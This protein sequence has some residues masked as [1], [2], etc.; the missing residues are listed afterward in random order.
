MA[1]T[2][3]RAWT[4]EALYEHFT[5]RIRGAVLQL[6]T[7][8]AGNRRQYL[9]KFKAIEQRFRSLE[10]AIQ[11]AAA[12]IQLQFKSVNELRSMV[13]DAQKTYATLVETRAQNEALV[14]RLDKVEQEQLPKGEYV[15]RMGALEKRQD[16]LERARQ[17][18]V[19][20]GT[21]FG[22]GW[23]A[24]ATLLALFLVALSIYAAL[25]P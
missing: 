13:T 20:Q 24:A 18:S 23:K 25:K 19:A 10:K 2:N 1:D 7:L 21:G 16:D 15:A 9:E 11:T 8:I 6:K 5:Q 12:S 17:A 22:S 3:G 14:R 4:I